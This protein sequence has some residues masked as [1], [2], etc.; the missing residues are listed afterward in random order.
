MD[1]ENKDWYLIE[2]V[3]IIDSPSLV[4]YLDRVK[5]NIKL[6]KGMIDDPARLRPHVKTHKAA[7]PTRLLMDAG[8]NKFKCAT[9]AEAEM[10][11]D[12]GGRD[13]LLA[14]Q[15]VGPKAG[16]LI[17]LIQK[18]PEVDFAC[19]VDNETSAKEISTLALSQQVRVS[20]YLDLNVG[21]HRT[22]IRPGT[23]AIELYQYCSKLKNIIVKGLHAY[24]GNITAV[25]LKQRT[26]EC[27]EAFMPVWEMQN[28][29]L[30]KGY[31]NP[32]IVAG[33]SP[34]FPIHANRAGVECSP[35]TFIYWD[36][37]Y[38][39]AFPE[40]A[41]LPAALVVTRIIALPEAKTIC[42]DLG[43][44]AVSAENRL[45]KRIH[46]L[47]AAHVDFIGHSEEH[48]VVE[49]GI[50]NHYKIGD[51][52]YGLPMHICPTCSLYERALTVENGVVSG[53][54]KMVARDRK[55]TI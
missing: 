50:E 49:A 28:S 2:N 8:I 35:G 24:D 22:G 41:F 52:F 20:V 37:G 53:E 30:R 36:K 38:Q 48:L 6:L 45:D 9:I 1:Q 12:A 16:R 17:S 27:D 10:I 7:E 34:T 54:W 51:V 19:L 4:I 46:F 32:I 11:A 29:L 33:G 43:Y 31:P 18:Y 5:E 15:P 14:Y 25:S 26:K 23:K 40:Q 13:I 55:I 42:L 47:N 39:S 3:D 44:K 21:M